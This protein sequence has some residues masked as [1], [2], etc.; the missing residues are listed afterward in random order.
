[1]K[2]TNPNQDWFCYDSYTTAN[3]PK[4]ESEIF[5]YARKLILYN[6][7]AE[8]EF[9]KVIKELQLRQDTLAKKNPRWKRTNIHYTNGTDDSHC[10]L[11]IGEG[12]LSLRKVLGEFY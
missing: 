9:K 6:L 11:I 3:R 1:M 2:I 8:G 10:W 7:V 4:M 12:R 5:E